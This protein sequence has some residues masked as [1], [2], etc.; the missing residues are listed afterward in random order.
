MNDY[1]TAKIYLK[2]LQSENYLAI[3]MFIGIKH[4]HK[5]EALGHMCSA[6]SSRE[7]G[8]F[9][10]QCCGPS[11]SFGGYKKTCLAMTK[12]FTCRTTLK[13]NHWGTRSHSFDQNQPK[14]FIP[15]NR[16]EQAERPPHY[17]P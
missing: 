13:C 2:S 17:F 14:G 11:P 15:G 3:C 6:A 9:I 7:R 5:R 16:E 8:Q 10:Y 1:N 4:I 12:H